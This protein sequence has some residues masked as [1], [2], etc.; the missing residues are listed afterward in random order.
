MKK[1]K[2]IL[3]R[4]EINNL[5]KSLHGYL[6]MKKAIII[7]SCFCFFCNVLKSQNIMKIERHSFRSSIYHEIRSFRIALPTS[8]FPNTKYNVL[9]VLDADYTFDV[10]ASTAIYLQSFDYIPPTAVVA[11][12]YSTPGNRN[13]VGYNL[14]N[15]SLDKN[16]EL[17][18]NYINIDLINEIN[19][20]LPTSGF[21]TIIGH[22]Y[23]ASYL[24]YFISQGNNRIAS[25]ILF[26][27]EEMQLNSYY[28][29]LDTINRPIIRMITSLD[30]TEERQSFGRIL[31][32]AL[33]EK[34]YDIKLNSI[35]ADHMSVIPAGIMQALTD[36]YDKY[37]NIDSVYKVI[38]DIDKPLWETFISI[39]EN[40]K[41]YY[42]QELPISGTYISAFL[43]T[44]IQKDEKES[45]KRFLEYYDK[46]LKNSESDPNAL[47]VMGDL[48]SKLEL[49]KEANY[50][51][52][53][54]LE[55]YKKSGQDHETLYWRKVYALK[56]LP[57]LG[58][59]K[60]AWKL[61]EGGKQIYA[62]EKAIFSYYQGV[63]S[64]TNKFNIKEGIKQLKIAMNYPDVLENNFVKKEEVE[65][66]LNKGIKMEKLENP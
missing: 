27:P 38:K 54:C 2:I 15:N 55:G 59:Y 10:I 65:I 57:K 16:G 45:I 17:F 36:L 50:Y 52:H 30:D 41:T 49:W 24:N 22:S 19:R 51:L 37:Y 9:L 28:E 5:I 63:L 23:T 40:N 3:K 56:V 61:L 53:R 6:I 7:L 13:D 14:L 12:D 11:I 31:F 62:T 58:Q 47:G 4:R 42:K 8:T 33:R 66:L 26:S 32:K 48:L 21:N 1:E 35:K 39:N 20:K 43:W 46:S 34:Q 64:I 18:Y 44:A 60:K 29:T 25:Y